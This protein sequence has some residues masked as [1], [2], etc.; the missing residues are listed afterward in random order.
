MPEPSLI[1]LPVV[2]MTWQMN[3]LMPAQVIQHAAR[4]VGVSLSETT[5]GKGVYKKKKEGR[6]L[7]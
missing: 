4:I 6:E 1:V 3:D 5:Y 2:L 7:N